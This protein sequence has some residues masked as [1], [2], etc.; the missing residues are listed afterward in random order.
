MKNI[1]NK[2]NVVSDNWIS[3]KE[4]NNIDGVARP[5]DQRKGGAPLTDG[6]HYKGRSHEK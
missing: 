1:I 2:N 5:L 6:H 4:L 3:N